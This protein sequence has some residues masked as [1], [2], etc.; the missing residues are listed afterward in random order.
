MNLVWDVCQS[1]SFLINSLFYIVLLVAIRNKKT[2][3]TPTT[4][5]NII[6]T[7]IYHNIIHHTGT[8]YCLMFDAYHR[9]LRH[10]RLQ[11]ILWMMLQAHLL[12]TVI[13]YSNFK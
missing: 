1:R 4:T 10:T 8:S 7:G 13:F 9:D 3:D 6:G 2:L 11:K 12:M 5:Y